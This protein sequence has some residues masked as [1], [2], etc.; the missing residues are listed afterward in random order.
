M[1]SICSNNKEWESKD[2]LYP[3]T[4]YPLVLD[5][6][7]E[8]ETLLPVSK[9]TG[10]REDTLSLLYS[11]LD[12]DS[13]LVDRILQEIPTIQSDPNISDSDRLQVLAYRL[14]N[15][16]LYEQDKLV[17]K[18]AKVSDMLF[19]EQTK[20]VEKQVVDAAKQEGVVANVEPE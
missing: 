3:S 13:R 17:D 9:F 7:K 4:D 15:G 2:V 1:I 11:V 10:K 5:G 14:T 16:T 12:K 19:P 18:L 6:A 8:I 20:E